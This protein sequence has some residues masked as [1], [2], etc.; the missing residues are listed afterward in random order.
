[1]VYRGTRPLVGADAFTLENQPSRQHNDFA[2]SSTLD[3]RYRGVSVWTA[4]DRNLRAWRYGVRLD[5]SYGIVDPFRAAAMSHALAQFDAQRRSAAN[6]RG[7]AGRASHSAS[8]ER[9]GDWAT[10]R[11][12]ARCLPARSPCAG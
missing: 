12:R 1:M 3:T 9:R 7:L 4:L 11:G 5:G 8:P 6:A 2:P 10:P